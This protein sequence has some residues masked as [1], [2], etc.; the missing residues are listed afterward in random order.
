[1]LNWMGIV[2]PMDIIYVLII[3]LAAFFVY[4]GLRMVINHLLK[5]TVHHKDER[6][7]KTIKGLLDNVVKYAVIAALFLYLLSFFGVDTT[8]IG[9][10]VGVIGIVIG[11]ALQDLLKDIIA[12]TFIV[13]ENQF[14]I[15]D[16]VTIGT[17]K[18]KVA[19]LGLRTTTIEAE[20]GEL[21]T[22]SN[23][24]ILEVINFSVNNA[25][26]IVDF[27]LGYDNDVDAVEAFLEQFVKHLEATVTNVKGKF[28]YVGIQTV[29]DVITYRIEVEVAPMKQ[30]RIVSEILREFK[31]ELD[32]TKL[33]RK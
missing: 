5:S 15:G 2:I 3:G 16:I 18:G 31:I 11:L 24:N 8:A 19:A 32:K 30:Q 17:F 12:G 29:G 9:A 25:T 1:M 10:G 4:N 13:L 22:I 23:R 21:K 33:K 27:T 7:F 20:T 6:R 14:A 26:A 28:K